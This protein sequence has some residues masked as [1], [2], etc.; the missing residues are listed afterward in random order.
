MFSYAKIEDENSYSCS[1]CV[2]STQSGQYGPFFRLFIPSTDAAFAPRLAESQPQ[3]FPDVP[4]LGQTLFIECF[5]YGNPVP[6]YDWS[7]VDGKN[8]SSRASISNFGRILKIEK[9]THEDSGRYRCTAQNQ[10]GNAEGEI[11][12]TLKGPPVI[13]L[14]LYDKL[15]QLNGSFHFVC[16][17]ATADAQSI[18]EWFKDSKPLVP[19]L[20]PSSQ[21]KR[22]TVK[23]NKLWVRDAEVSD[24]GIYECMAS[25][26][27]G[28]AYATAAVKVADIAPKI[29]TLPTKIEARKGKNMHI[30]CIV[31]GLPYVR[32]KWRDEDGNAI[33]ARGRKRQD[34]GT[35]YI[36][37]VEKIDSG[38]YFC[39]ATNRAGRASTRVELVVNEKS[40]TTKNCHIEC[41]E[42]CDDEDN[43]IGEVSRGCEGMERVG[44]E[45]TIPLEIR[46]E[47]RNDTWRL[48]WNEKKLHEVQAIEF[49]MKKDRSWKK[50]D[51]MTEKIEHSGVYLKNLMPNQEYQFRVRLALSDGSRLASAPSNWIQTPLTAPIEE[52]K[53]IQWKEL[54]KSTLLINWTPIEQAYTSA[55]EHSRY[56]IS[57]QDNSENKQH[58]LDVAN[59]PAI[60]R[61]SPNV[62]CNSVQISIR[63]FNS[64]GPS[65]ISTDTV[66]FIHADPKEV[67]KPN[68]TVINST[69]VNVTWFC[70]TSVG[71]SITCQPSP[72]LSVPITIP[73]FSSYKVIPN[74]RP[75]TH[76]RC[77]VGSE[78]TGAS[79]SFAF[80]TPSAPPLA[81]PTITSLYMKD[82]IDS[83]T[84]ILE[85][86]PSD[87]P[88]SSYTSDEI[89]YE[90]EISTSAPSSSPVILRVPLSKL[91]SLEH[92]SVR[93]DGLR[94]MFLY[95]IRYFSRTA[96]NPGIRQPK[97]LKY[98]Y[99]AIDESENNSKTKKSEKNL[100]IRPTP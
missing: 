36:D 63:P 82:E 100:K 5:A 64:K 70:P 60:I 23:H 39:I 50:A 54:N 25:N 91:S 88:N 66:A 49:R 53:D 97:S 83:Y 9:A 11:S 90:I 32:G 37:R 56:H 7:R 79:H 8:L 48:A 92:P 16:H 28:A 13:V 61:L 52:V 85:W 99:P 62:S 19:L 18:V 1:L 14:P 2:Y 58:S 44:R 47:K 31:Q 78:E 30:E 15:V 29:Q 10:L 51:G 98:K 21:R 68:V 86:T 59:P 84:T 26:D 17:L 93:L 65:M 41:K 43:E 12:V 73:P 38:F 3:I 20:L 22:I 27:L 80:S 4:T 77:S 35:L 6:T 87:F 42:E 55:N 57:W 69:H 46:V 94:L 95:T 72:I 71:F 89:G 45:S 76:Y 40:N 67:L 74:L 24:S 33:L 34:K 81:P 75:N 96:G